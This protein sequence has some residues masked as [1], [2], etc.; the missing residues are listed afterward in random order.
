M[1]TSIKTRRSPASFPKIVAQQAASRRKARTHKCKKGLILK[2]TCSLPVMYRDRDLSIK[3]RS[4]L[5]DAAQVHPAQRPPRGIFGEFFA[6]S[7]GSA[8]LPYRSLAL[9]SLLYSLIAYPTNATVFFFF[10]V[11]HLPTAFFEDEFPMKFDL[12]LV[13]HGS[14]PRFLCF[15]FHAHI[16]I[17]SAVTCNSVRGERS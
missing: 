7:W 13:L 5:I 17:Q 1:S 2:D 12:S 4:M 15:I 14:S 11:L 10:V 6:S 8:L 16:C 3:A 9:L